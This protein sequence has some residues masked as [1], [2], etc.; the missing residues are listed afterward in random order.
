MSAAAGRQ[1]GVS[2]LVTTYQANKLL[3]VREA[4][5]ALSTLVRTFERPMGLAVD[6]RR[7]ALG[8]RNQ[9]W[10]MRNAPDIAPQVEPPGTHDACYLPRSSHVTG[11]IAG[12]EMAWAGEE[13]WVV[14]TRF[15]CLCTMH[16]DYSFVPRW[17]PPFITALAAEDRCHLNGLAMMDDRPK[18]VSTLG[19]TDARGG[20]RANKAKGG[21]LIDVPSGGIVARGLSM[22]HSPRLHE[23]RL[24]LLETAAITTPS[25]SAC[26]WPA[27]ASRAA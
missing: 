7:M 26:G 13:L 9:V 10:L 21:C 23:G 18:V 11:D 25:S 1:L 4:H 8:T 17:R 19:E 15:S 14:N 24:W 6:A 27:A 20:W 2:L 22:P 12:H 16:P 5:G 3:V